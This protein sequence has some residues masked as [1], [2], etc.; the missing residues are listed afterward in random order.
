MGAT[1]YRRVAWDLTPRGC[2][3]SRPKMPETPYCEQ[4]D[5]AHDCYHAH[6]DG[7][8]IKPNHGLST[9]EPVGGAHGILLIKFFYVGSHNYKD[10]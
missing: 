10:P 7:S 4:T 9:A 3:L 1:D 5:Q 2:A 8:G 6:T